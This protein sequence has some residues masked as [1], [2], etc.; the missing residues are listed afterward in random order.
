MSD[1]LTGSRQVTFHQ[2]LVGAR[3]KWLIDALREAVGRVDPLA[4]KAELG[5]YVPEDVQRILATAGIRDEE[6]FPTPVVLEA[7]PTLVGYYRLVLGMSQKTFYRRE[8]NMAPFKSMETSGVLR[9]RQRPLLPEF[10]ARIAE[11]LAEVIRQLSPSVTPRDVSELPLLT[12]GGQFQGAGNVIIGQQAAVDIFLAIADIVQG[13][14]MRRT[15]KLVE[16]RNA[17]ARTVVVTVA[18]DPDVRI[19]EEFGGALRNKVAIE[20]KGGTDISNVH[21]RAGEAEKSQ[22][23]A[24]TDGFRDFWTIIMMKGVDPQ[25]LQLESP[26]TTSWFDAAQVMGR[27]G[28]D[29]DEF[30]SRIVD[31]VGIP[32]R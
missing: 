15:E 20:I 9:P 13:Y 4:L 18:Q 24:R 2:L 29:W 25:K 28:P 23:K 5:N 31:A 7:Q 22:Q 1:A 8:T 11:P 3:K 30:R 21:N 32:G 26:T 10:C 12:L 6:V 27:D 16:I 17:S 19:Q 14:T